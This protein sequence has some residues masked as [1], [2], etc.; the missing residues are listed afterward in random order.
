MTAATSMHDHDLR[1]LADG[2][3]YAESPRW[4]D[5]ELWISDVHDLK[6]KALTLSGAVRDVVDVPQRPS[7]LAHRKD[8][9]LVVV[10][11][12]DRLVYTV[13]ANGLS[14]LADLRGLATGPLGDLAVDPAGRLWVDDFGYNRALDPAP[15][16]GRLIVVEPDGAARVAA[17]DLAF[18][19]GIAVDAS[20]TRLFVAETDADRITSFRISENGELSERTIHAVLDDHPDGLC[21]DAAG[22]MWVAGIG[23]G[24][25]MYLDDA[26]RIRKR[27]TAP[28]RN[29]TA[30][31]LGGEGRHTLFMC[32]ADI[33]RERFAA[34]LPC[35]RIDF[36]RVE[37][38]GGG[39]P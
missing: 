8:G 28:A 35:S 23:R 26:G 34:R 4:Y 33:S 20:G 11:S 21:L 18:P 10:S 39:M 32:S 31:V 3:V 5:G 29:G 1:L 16:P 17:E 36:L 6:V 15:V 22:G 9:V 7:G 19:N 25:F 2:L 27:I 30:C 13:G 24:E 14:P 12:L 37:V 38:P